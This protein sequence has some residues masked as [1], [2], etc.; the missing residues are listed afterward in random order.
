M[1]ARFGQRLINATLIRPES[2]TALQQERDAFKG[3]A[4]GAFHHLTWMRFGA[5]G[6]IG[7]TDWDRLRKFCL[8][9]S[10]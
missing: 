8:L 4:V 2:A 1:D 6:D 5:R 10:Q 3:K 7:K 9:A